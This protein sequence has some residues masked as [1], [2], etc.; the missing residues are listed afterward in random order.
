MKGQTGFTCPYC[1]ITLKTERGAKKHSCKKKQMADELGSDVMRSAYKLWA[2][3]FIYNGF[4]K[5]TD[6]TTNDFRRSPYFNYFCDLAA[7]IQNVW[8]FDKN[9]YVAWLCQKR[10][11][12]TQWSDKTLIGRYKKEI[13]V[14]GKGLE[15]AAL[16]LE[17]VM[18]W[19][20]EKDVPIKDFFRKFP[21]NDFLLWLESGKMSPWFLLTAPDR[22]ALIDRLS[23]PQINKML[24]HI[25]MDY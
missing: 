25:N 22:D 8:M 16:T 6:R 17:A 7:S 14:R 21:P 19:C 10:I 2:F 1:H 24:D 11:P 20:L 9:D 23:D 15:R 13:H 12:A 3:W 5:N 4:G 18:L